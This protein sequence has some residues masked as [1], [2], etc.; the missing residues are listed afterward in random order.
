MGP[1][2]YSEGRRARRAPVFLIASI[3]WG[4]E[5]IDV[6]I[7]NISHGGVL[8]EGDCVPAS[9]SAVTFRRGGLAASGIVAWAGGRFAGI[10]FNHQLDPAQLLRNVGPPGETAES[11]AELY[12]RPALR[13]RR[14]TQSEQM[15]YNRLMGTE[16]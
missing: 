15:W 6:R 12:R 2:K 10:E 16:P 9:G 11:P 14:L 4:A 13:Q 8:V 1:S 3:E 5:H 7:R